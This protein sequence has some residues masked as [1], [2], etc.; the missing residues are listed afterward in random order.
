MHLRNRHENRESFICKGRK[1]A[2]ELR[3]KRQNHLPQNDTEFHGNKTLHSEP[4]A[5]A[6]VIKRKN[7]PRINTEFHGN[8]T[9]HSEPDA[10]ATVI[11]QKHLP[12]I[13]TEFHG[14]KTLHSEPDA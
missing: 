2:T 4:D 11:K 7:L 13:N 14:N 12:R 1:F 5:L 3:P 8:K 10:I 9:L 6:T